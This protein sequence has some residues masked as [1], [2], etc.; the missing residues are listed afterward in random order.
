MKYYIVIFEKWQDGEFHY[1]QTIGAE[2]PEKDWRRVCLPF[3]V[4]PENYKSETREVSDEEFSEIFDVLIE[5]IE[6]FQISV[7]KAF[8]R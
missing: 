2:V 6:E 8:G 1:R 4:V 3:G 7:K 5:D